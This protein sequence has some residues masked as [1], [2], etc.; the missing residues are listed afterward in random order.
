MRVL[1]TGHHGYI[2]SLLMPLLAERGI[3][4]VGLDSDLF[5][6]CTFGPPVAE[7]WPSRQMDL[8]DATLGDLEGFDAVMHLAALSNDP[9]GDINP[10]LTYDINL[11]GSLRLARLAKQAGVG[12][13][14]FS[15]SCSNYGASGDGLL[16]EQAPLAPLTPYAISKVKLEEELTRLADDT[17]T[18]VFLR[19]ATAY[20]ISPRL[21]VDLVLNNL[22]AWAVTTGKIVLQSDGTPWRPIV[23]VEDICRAFLVLLD[24][25][26]EKVHAQAFNICASTENYRIR[27]LAGIVGE[28]IPG[29]EVTFAAGAGP[30]ARNYRVSGDKFAQTFPEF[31]LKWNARSGAREIYQAYLAAGLTQAEFDGPRF[32]RLAHIRQL[33]EVGT[34]SADLRWTEAAQPVAS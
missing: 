15:S 26:R 21:R 25:P 7:T 9:L 6:N 2:G 33:L 20:G 30:D 3:D 24:A 14:L 29:C 34:L 10:N 28:T 1:V 32:K 16:D 17:F 4:A 27:E 23:H 13:F 5:E 19:N 31:R 22:T 11:E 18:P 12:R 8:R